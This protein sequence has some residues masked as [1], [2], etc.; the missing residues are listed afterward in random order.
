ME[1]EPHHPPAATPLAPPHDELLAWL[2]LLPALVLSWPGPN[3]IAGDFA[4]GDLS[5]TGVALLAALPAAL[6]V[7]WQRVRPAPALLLLPLIWIALG[8]LPDGTDTLQRDRAWMVLAV[9]MVLALGAGSLAGL[10]RQRLVSG[11]AIC[12]GLLLARALAERGASGWGGVLGNSGELSAAATP[13]A[14]AGLMLWTGAIGKQRWLGL[15]VVV[16]LLVHAIL[17]PVLTTLVVL[18]VASAAAAIFANGAAA[19]PGRRSKPL[20][21]CVAAVLGLAFVRFGPASSGDVDGAPTDPLTEAPSGPTAFGGVEVRRRVWTATTDLVRAHPLE[22]VGAG[23]FATAFPEFRD[24]EE[25]ELSGWNRRIEAVT[26]VE[27]PHNDWLLPF[28]EG[29][30][31]VGIIWVGFL[32]AVALAARRHLS[33][34]EVPDLALG[35]AGLGTLGSALAGSPLWHNAPASVAGFAVFGALLSK[36]SLQPTARSRRLFA[37]AAALLLVLLVPRAWSMWMLGQSLIETTRTQSVTAQELA[38][39]RALVHTPDSIVA[40]SMKARARQDAGQFV[41]ALSLWERALA[42]R[43]LRF[44]A[45]MNSG[46]VLIR[47]GRLEEAGERFDRAF[48]LDPLHPGLLRN[49]VACA[50]DRGLVDESLTELDRL[51][52]TG[53]SDP[54]WLTGLGCDL[55]L[56]GM[57]REALPLLARADAR[58]AELSGEEAW[59]LDAEFRRG[60][61]STFA[62]AF[63]ALAHLTWAREHAAVGEWDDARRSYHQSLRISRERVPPSGPT[64]VRMELAAVQLR[65]RMPEDAKQTLEGLEPRLADWAAMPAWAGEALLELQFGTESR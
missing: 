12:S 64:R 20:I 53:H 10:G 16:L 61:N 43:P 50:A 35:A 34:L 7:A 2:L 55:L 11:L 27:H 48:A 22:G 38:V 25:L 24:P 41:E 57:D 5:G 19:L 13:G 30:L 32:V 37:P 47:L 60:G 8:L 36:R 9:G 42:L 63:K 44:E 62:D 54:L 59:A 6:L 33:S 46:F 29:G 21:L 49:R 26:E 28:A 15:A 23:Q 4:T 40:L 51:E 65:A 52:A 14:L 58:F 1:S 18:A 45:L 56:R 39:D 17:A 31:P 3:P